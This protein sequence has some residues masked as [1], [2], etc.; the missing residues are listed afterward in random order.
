M[1]R[2]FRWGNTGPFWIGSD[3]TNSQTIEIKTLQL[4]THSNHPLARN[5]ARSFSVAGTFRP[6]KIFAEIFGNHLA[7]MVQGSDP[8]DELRIFYWKTGKRKLVC[9]QALFHPFFVLM[10]CYHYKSH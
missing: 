1:I 8:L 7:I 4:S 6:Q 5:P 3:S 9:C 2:S 10:I